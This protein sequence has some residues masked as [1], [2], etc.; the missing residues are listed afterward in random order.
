MSVSALVLVA[1]L[2]SAASQA[3]AARAPMELSFDRATAKAGEPVALPV[4]VVSDAN[5]QEPFQITLEFPQGQLTFQKIEPD[6]LAERAK[7]KMSGAVVD[8]PGKADRRILRIDVTPGGS[9]F[10]PSGLVAHAHFLVTGG[11][12]DGDIVLDAA[13]VAPSGSNPVPTTEPAKITVF[14]TPV[15]ACFFY[16]H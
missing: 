10:F 12:P 7:W 8:H 4:Y 1:A 14:T 11:T 5:Y 15:F 2:G 6:Y 3:Q 9:T 13:L 16:M